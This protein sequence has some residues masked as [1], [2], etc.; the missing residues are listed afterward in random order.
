MAT[1]EERQ[2]NLVH[3]KFVG[4]IFHIKILQKNSKA[5]ILPN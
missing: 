3:S 1:K 4:I 5:K 2:K